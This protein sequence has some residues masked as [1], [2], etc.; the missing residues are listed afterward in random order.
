MKLQR[1]IIKQF[2]VNIFLKY[3]FLQKKPFHDILC[4]HSELLEILDFNAV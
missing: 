2:K 4:Q 3:P 1:N